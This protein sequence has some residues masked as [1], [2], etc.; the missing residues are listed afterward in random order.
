MF[1]LKTMY[2]WDRLRKEFPF[3]EFGDENYRLPVNVSF[4]RSEREAMDSLDNLQFIENTALMIRGNHEE[5]PKLDHH[6][7]TEDQYPKGYIETK[8]SIADFLEDSLRPLVI[9]YS[10]KPVTID[11]NQDLSVAVWRIRW[12]GL[13]ISYL[14]I[15][16][17]FNIV[18]FLNHRDHYFS[19]VLDKSLE[20]TERL[21][22][23]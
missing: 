10:D 4:H 14:S 20:D 19:L 12:D 18:R 13:I 17:K 23:N 11:V 21:G 3:L 8:Y 16:K 15:I 9:P 1:T 6:Y 22:S 5:F 7:T 2:D